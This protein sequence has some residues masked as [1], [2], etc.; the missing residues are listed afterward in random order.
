MIAVIARDRRDPKDQKQIPRYARN[1][2]FFGANKLESKHKLEITTLQFQISSP[3]LR[4]SVVRFFLQL[5]KTQIAQIQIPYFTFDDD[6]FI[7]HQWRTISS[8]AVR[9]EGIPTTMPVA[10]VLLCALGVRRRMK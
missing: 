8:E 7:N 5:S 1:D 3:C 6:G 9:S 2:N 10:R 4:D